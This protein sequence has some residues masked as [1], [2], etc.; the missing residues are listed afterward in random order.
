MLMEKGML[1]QQGMDLM[2]LS[3]SPSL[4]ARAWL[5]FDWLLSDWLL[6][7]GLL[8]PSADPVVLSETGRAAGPEEQVRMGGWWRVDWWRVRLPVKRS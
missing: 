8:V 5:L 3:V 6:S 4:P 1:K 7:E 2:A